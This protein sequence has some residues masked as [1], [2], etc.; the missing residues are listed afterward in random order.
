M[1]DKVEQEHAAPHALNLHCPANNCEDVFV[2][3]SKPTL[4]QFQKHILSH[5]MTVYSSPY[6]PSLKFQCFKDYINHLLFFSHGKKNNIP[7]N[8]ISCECES[9]HCILYEL[10]NE[11]DS[12]VK[13]K[14][15][16]IDVE[17]GIATDDE[18][19]LCRCCSCQADTEHQKPKC[20]KCSC[21]NCTRLYEKMANGFGQSMSQKKTKLH[22]GKEF[23]A[24]YEVSPDDLLKLKGSL[25]EYYERQND[26]IDVYVEMDHLSRNLM[27]S[28]RFSSSD[29]ESDDGEPEPTHGFSR[30]IQFAVGLSLLANV[31]L[32]I[33][34]VIAAIL[35]GSMAVLAS[36]FD[37]CLD[38]VSGSILVFV[39]RAIRKSNYD[40]FP[41]GKARLE[42]I[43]VVVFSAIMGTA[44]VQIIIEAANVLMSGDP[45]IDI[46]AITG[47]IL[48]TTVILKVILFFYCRLVY[49]R[50]LHAEAVKALYQD[51]RN[52][53]VSNSFGCAAAAA[54]AFFWWPVDSIAA[55]AIALFIITVWSCTAYEQI[56]QLTGSSASNFFLNQLVY[57]G[58]SHNKA[59][60]QIDSVKA[61][62]VGSRYF[63]EVDVVLPET[64]P[65]K[66]AHDVGENLQKKIESLPDVERAFVHV[67][68]SADHH[69]SSEHKPL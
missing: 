11:D 54:G 69:P 60:T 16:T 37:S 28:A 38:L 2:V 36:A 35:S 17:E 44:A 65:V 25:K 26:L 33:I 21:T 56:Q 63:C 20:D 31:F 3:D 57:L 53:I 30:E 67:D 40:K 9:D 55:I 4:D 1:A 22:R 46:D 15:V 14:Q 51:H 7:E 48:G 6:V 64:M 49:S 62:H 29:A 12:P 47:S 58:C 45:D 27:G 5:C 59:I 66:L 13:V 8:C 39:D 34:K 68:Y 32:L 10:L 50:N 61:F 18:E 52:D 24:R 19:H 23:K 41:V 43:G 42:P